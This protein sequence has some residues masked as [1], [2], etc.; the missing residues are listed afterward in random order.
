MYYLHSL[1]HINL[2]FQVPE[3]HC[4]SNSSSPFVRSEQKKPLKYFLKVKKTKNMGF[5]IVHQHIIF[6]M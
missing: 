6:Y 2:H 5:H 1:S 3:K 4:A